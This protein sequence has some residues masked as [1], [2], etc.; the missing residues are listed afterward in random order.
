[1][2]KTIII[3]VF[4]VLALGILLFRYGEN[5]RNAAPRSAFENFAVPATDSGKSPGSLETQ[6][7]A[8]GSVEVS[9]TALR[10]GAADADWSFTVE[11]NT[12]SGSL[13]D[14]LAAASELRDGQGNVYT[15]VAWDGAPPGGHHREGILKFAPISP[16][17]T[18]L[19]LVV[20]GVGGVAERTF[21]WQIKGQ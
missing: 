4:A 14:D 7:N 20:K 11:L 10:G 21:T 19:A 18:S 9:V 15:P 13:D 16:Y 12:H 3:S 8:E 6:T 5:P 2:N 17:P 1:M